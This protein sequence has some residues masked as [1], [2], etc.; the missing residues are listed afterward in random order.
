MSGVHALWDT[1]GLWTISTRVEGKGMPQ[2]RE[3]GVSLQG[4]EG[5]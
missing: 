4:K 2:P 5:R 3:T 1:W